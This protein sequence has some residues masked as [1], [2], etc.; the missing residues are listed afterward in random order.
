MDILSKI[1]ARKRLRIEAAKK[2]TDSA[3]LRRRA[4][5]ARND[6]Q[7]H[8]FL[9]AFKQ[10]G[11]NIIA[12]FKR[13][14]PSKGLI[15]ENADPAS[16]T[17]AYERGGARA[18]SVLTEEEFFA[19]SLDDLRAARAAV[20]VPILRKDFIIDEY[21]VYETAVSGADALLAIVAALDDETM[22]RLLS[23]TEE[24][25]MDALVEVHD[26]VELQR[27][28]N[29]GAKL[30]GVNNRNLKTFEVTTETSE[31]LAKLVP[32][33]LVLI[34]ESGLT[35]KKVK[36]L[37]ALGYR[38]FLVGETLMRAEDPEHALRVFCGVA[39]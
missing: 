13:Q 29:V 23:L 8:S 35:P 33:H 26:E 38:G 10:D 4:E 31:R 9:N 24:L 11:I 32:E 27:A 16:I 20:S 25:Q 18:V 17:R 7:A 19:G 30:I 1:V 34:S 28:I 6:A 3:Q 14:S 22:D 37:H 5:D 2:I 12:E 39:S 36:E 21:Q 15:R